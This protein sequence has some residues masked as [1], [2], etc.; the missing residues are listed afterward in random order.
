MIYQK[1]KKKKIIK[2]WH[3]TIPVYGKT[4]ELLNLYSNHCPLMHSEEFRGRWCWFLSSLYFFFFGGMGNGEETN[5]TFT[6]VF[7]K[8]T[9]CSG[10]FRGNL[11]IYFFFPFFPFLFRVR[12][13]FNNKVIKCAKPLYSHVDSCSSDESFFARLDKRGENER[14]ACV[15]K[16]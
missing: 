2:R 8:L 3:V 15:L 16:L 10:P 13:F 4:C 5:D 7:F 14:E 6:P 9:T 11:F 12:F 1:G